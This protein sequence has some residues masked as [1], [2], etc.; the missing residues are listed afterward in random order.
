MNKELL[1]EKIDHCIENF[2]FLVVIFFCAVIMVLLDNTIVE[3]WAFKIFIITLCASQVYY[4][5]KLI[6][7]IQKPSITSKQNKGGKK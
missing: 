6:I 3:F 4:I 5:V 7:L 2:G 1:N